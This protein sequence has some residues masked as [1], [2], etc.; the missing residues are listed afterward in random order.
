MCPITPPPQKRPRPAQALPHDDMAGLA[1]ASKNASLL[2]ST[3]QQPVQRPCGSPQGVPAADLADGAGLEC[4]ECGNRGPFGWNR[5]P[6]TIR[7]FPLRC[8][9]C[10]EPISLSYV[11]RPTND[12]AQLNEGHDGPQEHPATEE[13]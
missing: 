1:G 7:R 13:D 8:M 10:Q 2:A 4:P 9:D 6:A 5:Q 11:L 3:P 12:S